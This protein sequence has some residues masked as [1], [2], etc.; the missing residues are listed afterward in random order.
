MSRRSQRKYPHP[1]LNPNNGITFRLLPG[2]VIGALLHKWFTGTAPPA[3]VR[4]KSRLSMVRARR[5]K[6]EP[7]GLSCGDDIP[8]LRLG[9]WN[10]LFVCLFHDVLLHYLQAT[11]GTAVNSKSAAS[12]KPVPEEEFKMVLCVNQELKMGKGKIAAQCSHAAVGVVQKFRRRIPSWFKAWEQGGQAKIAL[13]VDSTQLL[14]DLANAG[15]L[16]GLGETTCQ[17]TV[18]ATLQTHH[19]VPF[20]IW[21]SAATLHQCHSRAAFPMAQLQ[22][23]RMPLLHATGAHTR[24]TEPNRRLLVQH[25]KRTFHGT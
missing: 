6:E 8:R 4:R 11:T 20:C 19:C 13:K 21:V 23:C 3:G 12:D 22:W 25:N 2:L 1:L 10:A 17:H 14:L 7:A 18:P 16:A 5:A 15:E 9:I 24:T